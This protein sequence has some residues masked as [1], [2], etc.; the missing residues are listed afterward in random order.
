MNKNELSNLSKLFEEVV[1][2]SRKEDVPMKEI[3][4][5]LSDRVQSHEIHRGV[6]QHEESLLELADKVERELQSMEFDDQNKRDR[7][8]NST[9][10][11]RKVFA[12]DTSN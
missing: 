11:L 8:E 1:K 12:E 3:D 7:I 10:Q 2:Y 6:G 9:D 5:D 4:I